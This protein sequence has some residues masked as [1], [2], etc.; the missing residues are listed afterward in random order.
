MFE[1]QATQ[2]LDDE[3]PQKANGPGGVQEILS[4]VQQAYPAQRDE[5]AGDISFTHTSVAQL[6]E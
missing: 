4:V 5:V 1:L 3:E 2:L 6:V